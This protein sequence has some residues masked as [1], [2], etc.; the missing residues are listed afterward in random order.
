MNRIFGCNLTDDEAIKA[1][2]NIGV[3]MTCGSCASIF[4]TGYTCYEHTCGKKSDVIIEV[5][6]GTKLP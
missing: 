6:S 4:F 2:E 3:D 5:S 1:F